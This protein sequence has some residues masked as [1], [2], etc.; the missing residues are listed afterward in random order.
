MKTTI[1]TYSELE[2]RARAFAQGKL[3]LMVLYGP[4]GTSKSTTIREVLPHGANARWV[5]GT[6]SAFGLF[7]ELRRYADLPF[8]LDDL[9]DVFRDKALVRLLKQ[10]CQTDDKRRV[11]WL[12]KANTQLLSA[13]E[14]TEEADDESTDSDP[15]SFE[16]SSPV[17]LIV[18]D[19]QKLNRH[20]GAV[21]DRGWEI[22]FLPSGNE[23]HSYVDSW[24]NSALDK[25]GEW[26]VEPQVFEFIG[27]HLDLVAEPSI[28]HYVIASTA[29]RLGIDWRRDL[30]TNWSD[31]DPKRLVR[32]L[33]EEAV[34][35][36]EEDRID[37][38]RDLTGLSRTRYFE[39]KESLGL[40][41]NRPRGGFRPNAGR[42]PGLVG[43]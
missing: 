36:R 27:E 6:A 35:Q 26:I 43:L 9:D 33:A 3:P 10:V 7:R 1:R 5:N 31:V 13:S 19:W 41:G 14:G 15:H 28:R 12:T 25:D 34:Y 8:V 37:R 42:K 21:G 2:V 18:N 38:F 4:P 11:T 32:R 17:V 22:E 24:R 30:M 16:T 23:I 20:V 39:I 29:L 40:T